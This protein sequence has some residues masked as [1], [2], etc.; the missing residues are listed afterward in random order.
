MESGWITK[1]V[2]T[3]RPYHYLFDYRDESYVMATEYRLSAGRCLSRGDLMRGNLYHQ[4][5]REAGYGES[6]DTSVYIVGVGV[7]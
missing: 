2:L 6:I 7:V 3:A 5:G 4:H 1:A